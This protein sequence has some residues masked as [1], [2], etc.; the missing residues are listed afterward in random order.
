[1][2]RIRAVVV[3]G[4]LLDRPELDKVLAAVKIAAAK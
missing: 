3:R 2:R 1:V 4:R